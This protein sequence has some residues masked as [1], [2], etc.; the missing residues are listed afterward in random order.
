MDAGHRLLDALRRRPLYALVAIAAVGIVVW[1]FRPR[2]VPVEIARVD[3]QPVVVAFVEEGRT[4]VH[5]RY[6]IAA[7]LAGT[8]ERIGIE[9][10]DAV[11]AGQTLA[12]VRASRA[13]LL[14]ASVRAQAGSALQRTRDE[15]RA[16]QAALV[17]AAAVA[18][19]RAAARSRVEA[20]GSQDLVARAEIDAVR[21]QAASAA[22]DVHAAMARLAATRSAERSAEA[23]LALEG[24]A[25][26][27]RV[28]VR[29]PV[30]GRILRRLVESETPVQPGEPLLEMADLDALEV[31]VDVLSA[32]AVRLRPGMPVQV[33]DWGG[34]P[35]AATV[36][37]IEPG[38]FLKVSA[39]G[40]DEQ[41]VPVIVRF[42][43]PAPAA[44]GDGFRV[45]ARFVEWRGRVPSVPAAA[46]F[47]DGGAWA[48]YT[49]Q[50]GRARLR[51][52]VLSHA[53]E[54]RVEIRSGLARGDEVIAYPGDAV[55]DGVRVE[56][57]SSAR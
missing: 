22:A 25:A 53:G 19:E 54:D 14:D 21:A 44:L 2:A 11:T 28:A 1:A 45:D 26:R 3:V 50:D 41:R 24:S 5:D 23:V 57:A 42:D 12:T 8:V 34:E 38:G 32:D 35:L 43:R 40:V 39:L 27:A 49:V 16:A 15:T 37:R 20:L 10:G 52:V 51:R 7:P 29:A 9:P 17:A 47:R 48:V 6:V 31:V 30:G 36:L 4:R 56:A 33:I 46:L 13:A 55:R 18:R